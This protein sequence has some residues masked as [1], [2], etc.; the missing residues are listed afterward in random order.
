[1]FMILIVLIRAILQIYDFK[2]KETISFSAF[3]VI[4]SDPL[5]EDNVRQQSLFAISSVWNIYTKT[6]KDIR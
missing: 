6:F 4:S 1:M 5:S 2:V 3:S